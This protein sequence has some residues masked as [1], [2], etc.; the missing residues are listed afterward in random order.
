MGRNC[1][2][3]R[4]RRT[5]TLNLIAETAGSFADVKEVISGRAAFGLFMT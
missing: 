4:L 2:Q 3:C 5:R 1:S